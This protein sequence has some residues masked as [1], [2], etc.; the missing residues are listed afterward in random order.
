MC[1]H[2][3]INVLNTHTHLPKTMHNTLQTKVTTNHTYSAT[4]Q[5]LKINYT[6]NSVT[7][8]GIRTMNKI[9]YYTCGRNVQ[10]E[11]T[12]GK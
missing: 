12:K 5:E 9:T 11:S 2:M 8:M 3:C 7:E 4:L 10:R 1:M 6:R